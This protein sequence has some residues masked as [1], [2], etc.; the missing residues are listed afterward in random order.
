MMGR[1]RIEV[2][3]ARAISLENF[4]KRAGRTEYQRGIVTRGADGNLEVRTTGNQGSGVLSSMMQA[5]A[6]IVLA[7]D[8]ANV[9]AGEWVDVMRFDGVI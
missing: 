5:N 1:T 6:L 3:M 4:R 7:H 9:Q 2:P 8:S